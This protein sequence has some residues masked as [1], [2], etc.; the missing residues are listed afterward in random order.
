MTPDANLKDGAADQKYQKG[1]YIDCLQERAQS[2]SA[3]TGGEKKAMNKADQMADN[4]KRTFSSTREGVR[5]H[6]AGLWSVISKIFTFC[7]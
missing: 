3:D 4:F 1:K 7:T 6:F 2:N 5:I